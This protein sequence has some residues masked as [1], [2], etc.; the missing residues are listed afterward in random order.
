LEYLL[1]KG[2]DINLQDEDGNTPVHLYLNDDPY[3]VR[4]K[5]II[6]FLIAYGFDKSLENNEGVSASELIQKL[7]G[8]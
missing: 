3:K 6:D 4:E 1:N 7:M 8:D 5:E 2:L